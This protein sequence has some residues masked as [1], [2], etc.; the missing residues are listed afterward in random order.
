MIERPSENP[1]SKETPEEAAHREMLEDVRRAV[2][3]IDPSHR[4]PDTVDNFSARVMEVE[5]GVVTEYDPLSYD[6]DNVYKDTELQVLHQQ[7]D[8][9][10]R[11]AVR[12][13]ANLYKVDRAIGRRHEELRQAD[14]RAIGAA[15]R[16]VDDED[17]SPDDIISP[18][19]SE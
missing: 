1:E 15:L 17:F 8:V 9:R 12:A 11:R 10:Y 6:N 7:L 19:S 18:K 4:Y 2:D 14:I 5:M 16:M 13:L 3:V